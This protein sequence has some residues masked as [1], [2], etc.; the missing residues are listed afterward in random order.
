MANGKSFRFDPGRPL[1]EQVTAS[2]LNYILDLAESNRLQAGANYRRQPHGR[3]G[4][5]LDIPLGSGG[6][7]GVLRTPLNLFDATVNATPKV[8]VVNG[9]LASLLPTGMMPGGDPAYSFEVTGEGIIYG[10]VHANAFNVFT[11]AW[12]QADASLPA[13]EDDAIYVSIGSYRVADDGLSVAVE[14]HL[15]GSVFPSM[16]YNYVDEVLYVIEWLAV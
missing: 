12:I 6:G 5:S 7:A 4:L 14:S 13:N 16:G 9:T 15:R 2:R 11:D 1:L 10:G 8:G 3:S